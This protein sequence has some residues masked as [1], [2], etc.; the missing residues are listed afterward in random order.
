[1]AVAPSVVAVAAGTW[2]E[3]RD[4]HEVRREGTAAQRARDRN[5]SVFQRLSHDFQRAPVEFG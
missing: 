4:Q 1:M 3:R 5:V 2:V